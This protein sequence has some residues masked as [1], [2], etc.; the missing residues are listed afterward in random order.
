M[1]VGVIA[2]SH[3]G[4]TDTGGMGDVRL[5]IPPCFHIDTEILIKLELV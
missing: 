2:N 5:P 1:V 4:R 3:V